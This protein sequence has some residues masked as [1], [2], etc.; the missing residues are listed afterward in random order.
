ME[1]EVALR[2]KRAKWL[3]W[4]RAGPFDPQGPRFFS[5]VRDQ[6]WK[7]LL[8]IIDL[9][10]G[11]RVSAPLNCRGEKNVSHGFKSR[12]H[13]SLSLFTTGLLCE[14]E[15]TNVQRNGRCDASE[16]VQPLRNLQQVSSYL[17]SIRLEYVMLSPGYVSWK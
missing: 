15:K 6:Q 8:G 4:L 12:Q 14:R 5:S 16:T 17:Y 10:P 2:Q 7:R 1:V 13:K 9:A 11:I 3:L